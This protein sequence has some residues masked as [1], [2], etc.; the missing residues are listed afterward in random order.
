M[1]QRNMKLCL[2]RRCVSAFSETNSY[3]IFRAH[4]L[5]IIKES[6]DFCQVR[7]GYDYVI[8]PKIPASANTGHIE[9][10]DASSVDTPLPN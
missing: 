3:R 7:M 5:T 1:N 8:K 2:C 6:C 4:P 9:S 10:T